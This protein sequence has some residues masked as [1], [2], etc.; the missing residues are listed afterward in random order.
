NVAGEEARHI[1]L[2]KRF[3]KSFTDSF[4]TECAVIGLSEAVATGVLKHD[5]QSVTIEILQIKWM[6]PRQ[7]LDSVRDDTGI[8]P[9]FKSLLKYHWM[10]EAS[11]ARLDQLMVEALAESRD[12]AGIQAAI[13]GYLEIGAFLDNGLKAQAGF[14]LD[15]FEQA[16]GRT[17]T[18]SEREELQEQQHQALRWT[19]L[20]SGMTHSQFLAAL[21]SLS[22]AAAARVAEIAPAFC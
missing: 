21:E 9:L 13:D 4:G 15:A 5:T 12:E 7:Y 18:A 1:A 8:D 17:L 11:H 19:Y 14:N 10:E 6:T 16:T 2:F 3:H 22:P 20:G